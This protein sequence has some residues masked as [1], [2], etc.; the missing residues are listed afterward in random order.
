MRIGL[1]GAGRIGASHAAVLAAHP[2][3]AE[4]LVADADAGRARAVAAEIGARTVEP[5]GELLRPGAVDGLVIAAATTAH[6][7]LI[8]AAARAGTPVFCE[9]P[10]ALDVPETVRV[11]REVERTRTPVHIGF[12]RRFDAG[13]RRARQALRGGEIGELHRVH[14]ITG[15]QEPP[16]ASYLPLSGGIFRDCHVH[17]FDILRWVTGRE[18]A[19]VYAAGANR[20]AAFFAEAGDVD[21]AAALL[22]L[23]DGTLVTLQGSRYNGAGHD[24]RMELA[25]TRGTIAVGLDERLPLTS[26]EPGVSFP[27]GDPWPNFWT[28]FTPAYQAEIDAFVRLAKSGGEVPCTVAEAL[29][30]VLVAEAADRSMRL[31][32]PVKLSEVRP[33]H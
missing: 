8:T 25:G 4:V 28:R 16:R 31:G 22:R 26:A 9:K 11:L 30:A 24:V 32:T 5:V 12:Q 10:V 3:V 23:D 33:A 20:G 6:P 29:E 15:D 1:V 13:Y 14:A 21:N 2:E 19:D 18:V 7:E 17:D 27:G